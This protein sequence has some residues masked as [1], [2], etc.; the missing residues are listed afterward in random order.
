MKWQHWRQ[1]RQHWEQRGKRREYRGITCKSDRRWPMVFFIQRRV[2]QS[3]FLILRRGLW[4]TVRQYT[5]SYLEY[6][7]Y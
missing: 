6:K 3:W 4:R 7:I 5:H 1:S 2:A